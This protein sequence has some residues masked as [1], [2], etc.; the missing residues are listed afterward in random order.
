MTRLYAI[1]GSAIFLVIAPG[2]VAGLVPWWISHWRIEPPLFGALL[3]RIAGGLLI[4]LGLIGLLDSFGRFAIQGL[5]TP[6]PVL[7][8]RHLVVTGLYRYVRNPM[9]VAVVSTILGQGL[10]LG[11]IAL[12]EYGTLV[13]FLMHL[14]VLVYEEPKL[15]ASFGDEYKSFCAGVPRWIPRVTPWRA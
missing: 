4:V 6:A 13:W 7:P 8:P 5:G 1:L 2:F 14:F 12:L 3:L 10:L 15:R 9:Y 11:N